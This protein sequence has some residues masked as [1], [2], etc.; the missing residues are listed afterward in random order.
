[1]AS[2]MTTMEFARRIRP[3]MVLN[4]VAIV[5]AFSLLLCSVDGLAHR[6]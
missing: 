6:V 5:A 2:K 4:G 3:R 1:M